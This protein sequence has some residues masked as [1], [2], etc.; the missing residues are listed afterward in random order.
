MTDGVEFRLSD[1]ALIGSSTDPFP[2]GVYTWNQPDGTYTFKGLSKTIYVDVCTTSAAEQATTTNTPIIWPTPIPTDTPKPTA[3]PDLGDSTPPPDEP[4][5][6]PGEEG[7]P[8]DCVEAVNPPTANLSPLPD[9]AI[10]VP[11]LKTLPEITATVELSAQVLI[12]GI[13]T[14]QDTILTPASDVISASNYFDFENGQI[15]A[16]TVTGYIQPSLEWLSLTN[17]DNVGYQSE[18]GALWA[19]APVIKPVLP[20]IAFSL[21]VVFVRFF[22]F[23]F[24]WFLKL[25]DIII[26]LIKLIPF[27]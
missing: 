27:V 26:N 19:L 25:I 1:Y 15:M 22:L 23:L 17:P 6:A 14:V 21:F 10:E 12:D 24:N 18:G 9:L 5:G 2:G 13:G 7:E 3:T 20:I 16:K 11:T 4:P 8:D